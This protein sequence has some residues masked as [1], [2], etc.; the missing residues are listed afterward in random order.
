MAT[1]TERDGQAVWLGTPPPGVPTEGD[2]LDGAA[3]DLAGVARPAGRGGRAGDLPPLTGGLVGYLGYDVVRRFERLPE[4]A[5][6]DLGLPELGMMLATD[7][8]VLDH[9]R[10]ASC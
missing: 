4:Q 5:V 10:P 9:Y 7:L 8:A 1:L 3:A 2:P 6:D